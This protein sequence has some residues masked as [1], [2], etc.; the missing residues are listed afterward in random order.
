MP[1]P[2]DLDGLQIIYFGWSAF[3]I[4][5]AD[6]VLYFNPSNVGEVP[7]EDKADLILIGNSHDANCS[8]EDIQKIMKDGSKIYGPQ[9]VEDTIGP[10]VLVVTEGDTYTEKGVEFNIVPA[11][12][13]GSSYNPRDFGFGF[14]VMIGG[15]KLY[16]AGDTDL[17]PGMQDRD[18]ID[19]AFL[20]IGGT[21][22]MDY[23]DASDSID[24]IKPKYVIP[25][26]YKVGLDSPVESFKH[27][28]SGRAEVVVMT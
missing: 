23:R 22:V 2:F 28:V 24:M 27:R 12:N 1:N 16:F 9:K 3:K 11:Y 17:I 21:D 19:I 25:M 15:K 5:T 4:K 18:D 13:E 7:E 10:D 6:A 26:H 20:P 8:E 14:E